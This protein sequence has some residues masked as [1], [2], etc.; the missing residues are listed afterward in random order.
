MAALTT[1][2]LYTGAHGAEGV[3]MV[4]TKAGATEVGSVQPC[5][6]HERQMAGRA[7]LLL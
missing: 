6:L 4:P 5:N 2:H 7:Q 3:S 1:E